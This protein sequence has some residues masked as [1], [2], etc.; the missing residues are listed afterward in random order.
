M[1]QTY[2][3]V[4]PIIP[5][6]LDAFNGPPYFVLSRFPR[7]GFDLIKEEGRFQKREGDSNGGLRR[8]G[9]PDSGTGGT[10]RAEAPPKLHALEHTL[11]AACSNESLVA[12]INTQARG[13]EHT[14][15]AACSN[16]S[17]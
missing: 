5:M 6:F 11:A 12:S 16:E 3:H 14:L 1:F 17:C 4:A 8:T 15:A 13:V 2:E 10:L 9:L 7:A